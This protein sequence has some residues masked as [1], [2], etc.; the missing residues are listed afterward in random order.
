VGEW[1]EKLNTVSSLENY[2]ACISLAFQIQDD[3]RD[4]EG[5]MQTLGKMPGSDHR[6]AKSTYAAVAGLCAAKEKVA[7][8]KADAFAALDALPVPADAL[9]QIT[10]VMLFNISPE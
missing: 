3:I 10:D 9:R 2:A 7:L 1:E 5:D 4:I 8:L 6:Q